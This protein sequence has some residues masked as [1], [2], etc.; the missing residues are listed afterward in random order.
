MKR[1]NIAYV[2]K[3]NSEILTKLVTNYKYQTHNY[4]LGE[5]SLPHITVCQF[6]FDE[7]SLDEV[8][9]KVCSSD[10]EKNITLNFNELSNISF[11]GELYWLSLLPVQRKSLENNF[12]IISKIIPPIRKDEYDPH[13]TLFNY[14]PLKLSPDLQK[15]QKESNVLEDEFELAIGESDEVGQLKSINFLISAEYSRSLSPF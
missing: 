12:E 6:Y 5:S 2:P 7:K 11:N 9:E 8:W 14:Y 1:F 13:L 3:T 15:I 4:C 10:A